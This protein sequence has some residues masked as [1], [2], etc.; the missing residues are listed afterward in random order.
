MMLLVFIAIGLIAVINAEYT[1]SHSSYVS[2]AEKHSRTQS[3]KSFKTWLENL[4]YVQGLN[5]QVPWDA[6]M[7]KFA[8]MTP[9][10]F[11]N[12]LLA[13]QSLDTTKLD[14]TKKLSRPNRRVKG[15]VESFDWRDEGAVTPVQ[16][17]GFVGT[18][19]TFSTVANIEGQYFLSTNTSLKL[20]EEFLVDCDGTADR[21]LNHADCSIF[22]GWPYLAYQFVMKTGGIPSEEQQPYCAGTGACMPCMAGPVDLCGPPPYSCDRERTTKVCANPE[23]AASI[24]DWGYIDSDETS[25]TTTL[26][27]VGP[28]SALLDAMQLQWYKGGVWTGGDGKLLSCSKTSLDH[29]VTITGFGVDEETGQEFWN[30]KNSWGDVRVLLYY[31]SSFL[32]LLACLCLSLSLSHPSIAPCLHSLTPHGTSLTIILP[33]THHL[34]SLTYIHTLQSWGEDGYFR[35]LRGVGE[36]GINTAL[37]SASI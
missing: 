13:R 32:F 34:T 26:Q 11:K 1:A 3:D 4:E 5:K 36:C 17:Q 33:S 6:G 23:T 18:C 29:A 25:L 30:V 22:G 16:D 15:N 37:T 7:T 19:W 12:S 2:W 24:T 21:D 8:D 31:C 20:S 28:L 10:E 35:I 14:K 9:Q 27:E